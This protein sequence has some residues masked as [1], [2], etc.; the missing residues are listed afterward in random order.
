MRRFAVSAF[1]AVP[2]SLLAASPTFAFGDCGWRA[3]C[4]DGGVRQP[5]VYATHSRPVFLRPGWREVVPLPPIVVSRAIPVEVR[6]GRWRTVFTPPL[7]GTDLQRV[8]VAPGI[9][10]NIERPILV[11]P[12]T[13][14]RVYEP[15][16]LAFINRSHVVQPGGVQVIDHP[17]IVAFGSHASDG[18]Y[19]PNPASNRPLEDGMCVILDVWGGDDPVVERRLRAGIALFDITIIPCCHSRRQQCRHAHPY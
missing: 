14:G 19:T 3:D 7:F 8:R 4:F 9:Y 18:H 15:P 10:E 11:R 13:V 5:D 16:V 17:P 1:L 2:L 6:P 12:G